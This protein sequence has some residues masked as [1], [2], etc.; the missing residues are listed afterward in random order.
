VAAFDSE[1]PPPPPPVETGAEEALSG[2][3]PEAHRRVLVQASDASVWKQ[4]R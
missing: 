4:S 2:R 1:R 3:E